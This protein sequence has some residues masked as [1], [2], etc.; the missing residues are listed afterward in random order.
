MNLFISLKLIEMDVPG[1]W[2]HENPRQGFI[3]LL[4]DREDNVNSA[5][6]KY[7]LRK[8]IEEMIKSHKAHVGGRKIGKHKTETAEGQAF[9]E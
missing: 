1:T 3:V 5:F 9:V 7:R 4:A 2:N 6:E 8:K